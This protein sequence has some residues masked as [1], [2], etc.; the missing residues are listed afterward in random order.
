MSAVLVRGSNA[1]TIL[2]LAR[3]GSFRLIASEDILDEIARVLAY[4]KLAK[5]HG[6]SVSGIAAFLEKSRAHAVI[7][8]PSG[9]LDVIAADPADNRYLECVLAG[10]A[11]Y[12][13]SGYHHLLDIREY[14]GIRIVNAASFLE[15]FAPR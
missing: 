6:L 8:A 1:W 14:R 4:P 10:N 5:R 9:R 13:V 12:I 11:G 15:L 7:A 3:E 2:E